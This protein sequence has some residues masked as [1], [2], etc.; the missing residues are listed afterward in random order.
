MEISGSNSNRKTNE[1]SRASKPV[2]L[3]NNDAFIT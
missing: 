1:S 2:V 3:A